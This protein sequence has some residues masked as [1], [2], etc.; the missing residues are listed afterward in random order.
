M[1]KLEVKNEAD[2]LALPVSTRVKLHRLLSHIGLG[3]SYSEQWYFAQEKAME[4]IAP[5]PAEICGLELT[6]PYRK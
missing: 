6:N 5:K 3:A 2:F 4:L 1:K